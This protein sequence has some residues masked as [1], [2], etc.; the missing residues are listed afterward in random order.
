MKIKS[1]LHK[2]FF[3]YNNETQNNRRFNNLYSMINGY[4]PKENV[5]MD[6][7]IRGYLHSSLIYEKGNKKNEDDRSE[8]INSE[9][10]IR[11]EEK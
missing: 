4:Y 5:D 3:K 10:E 2:L 11:E 8:N 6:S 9:N 7:L 1:E